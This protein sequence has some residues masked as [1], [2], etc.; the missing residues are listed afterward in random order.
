MSKAVNLEKTLKSHLSALEKERLEIASQISKKIRTITLVCLG[1]FGIA[2]L[3][4]LSQL[5]NGLP[6]SMVFVPLFIAA[7]VVS[8]IG[9]VAYLVSTSKP[10]KIY[11]NTIKDK[12]YSKALEAYNSTV[13][14][15]PNQFIAVALFDRAKLFGRHTNYKGDD[16]CRGNLA[17][18]RSFQ[19][20][21]LEVYYKQKS[22]QGN[23]RNRNSNNSTTTVFK[24]LFYEV[25][26]PKNINA[27]VKIVPDIGEGV[28]GDV[29]KFMQGVVNKAM[30]AMSVQDPIVRFDNHPDFERAFKVMSNEELVARRLLTPELIQQLLQFK[31]YAKGNLYLSFVDNA[32]YLGVKGGKFLDVDYKR[33]LLSTV[34]IDQLEENLDWA[35]GLLKHLEQ[36][37]TMD[38]NTA[39]SNPFDGDNSQ[40]NSSTPP[41][42]FGQNRRTPPP[43]KPSSKNKP[44][45]PPRKP[46]SK[47]KPTPPPRKSDSKDNPFLL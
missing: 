2:L 29:G 6:A 32:C 4:G 28:F 14:Y 25:Q 24:G 42:R 15:H 40:K 35:F 7:I 41:N 8:I 13:T 3:Y 20:S 30:S 21:E 18:G 27:R 33:S 43:K 44:T 37:T 23:R 19:F 16:L 22:Y 5:G 11:K 34:F 31:E 46:S 17:D 45:P 38:Q 12:I 36:I 39:P 47:N 26:L 9:G 10:K 1:L